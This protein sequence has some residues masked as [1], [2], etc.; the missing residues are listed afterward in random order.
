LRLGPIQAE[1][2][3]VKPGIQQSPLLELCCQRMSA[4]TSYRQAAR[5]IDLLS[6]VSV[7]AKTQERIVNRTPIEAPEI[8]EPVTEV[9]LDGGMVRLVGDPGQ[10]SEWKQYKAVRVNG[11][12]PGMAWF[13]DNSA[14]LD[15]LHHLSFVSLF[16][17]LGDGHAGIWSL[18]AQLEVPQVAEEIL[19]WYSGSRFREVQ[20]NP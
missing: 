9:D 12:G 6:G 4:K 7:S 17:C 5:D 15:W 20:H 18:F 10:P 13:Q 11:D 3:G 2:L 19:D 14:L 1:N 8:T 16:Y